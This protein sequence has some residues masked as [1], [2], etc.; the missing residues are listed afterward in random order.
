MKTVR[1]AGVV[2]MQ[3]RQRFKILAL[4]SG[5]IHKGVHGA[6]IDSLSRDGM[7]RSQK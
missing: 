5:N 3:F 6:Y 7:R 1:S 4:V 2:K